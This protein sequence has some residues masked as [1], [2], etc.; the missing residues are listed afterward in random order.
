MY[1][2]SRNPPVYHLD[3]NRVNA[4]QRDLGVNRLEEWHERGIIFLEYSWV[5]NTEAS[6][7]DKNR[8]L[9]AN[10]YTWT[11]PVDHLGDEAQRKRQIA[12]ITFPGGV[13]GRS[14]ENDVDIVYTAWKAGATLITNDG[15][16]KR[17]PR[18]ILGSRADL[19][20]IGIRVLSTD[21]AVSEIEDREYKHEED[22]NEI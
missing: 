16:S 19:R 14:D 11:E 17:Q 15:E 8:S 13:R 7:N 3:A 5:A 6:K 22:E 9:K 18:G 10:S 2:D 1:N 21:E 12:E 20:K 4:K